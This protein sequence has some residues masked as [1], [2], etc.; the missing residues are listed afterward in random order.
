[1]DWFPDGTLYKQ[2]RYEHGHESGAQ[3]MWY[4]DGSVRANYVVRDGRR[5]G[6]IG[7]KGCVSDA[8]VVAAS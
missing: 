5:Y 8:P 6:L 2:F 7:A 4:V 3:R 1:L